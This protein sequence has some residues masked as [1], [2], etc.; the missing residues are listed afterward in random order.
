MKNRNIE[1]QKQ[2][3]KIV[4]DAQLTINNQKMAA[5]TEVKNQVG[6]LVLEVTEKLLRRELKDKPE[7]EALI[8]QLAETSTLN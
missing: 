7:Q 5:I 6:T 1:Y 3:A 4:A 8:R 2:A